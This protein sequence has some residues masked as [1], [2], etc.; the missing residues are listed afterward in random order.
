M[1]AK[2]S[3]R[4]N[5][6]NNRPLFFS[7]GLFISLSAVVAVFEW[8]TYEDAIDLQVTRA[9]NTM[10]ELIDIPLTNQPPPPPRV[11]QPKVVEVPEDEEIEDDIEVS[12]DAEATVETK[13]EQIE[14]KVVREE[15][16]ARCSGVASWN[17]DTRTQP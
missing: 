14:I 9:E 3:D 7:I 12:V 4:A 15:E 16:D 5:L 8:K 11:Q 6:A 2:K 1:E 10:D 17:C 13:I